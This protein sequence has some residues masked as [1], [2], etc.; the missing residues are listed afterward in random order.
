MAVR[1]QQ[2][3]GQG[4]REYFY[5]IF[6]NKEEAGPEFLRLLNKADEGL[7]SKADDTTGRNGIYCDMIDTYDVLYSKT[8]DPF[9]L[10][11]KGVLAFRLG[12]NVSALAYMRKTVN[13]APADTHYTAAAIKWLHKLE[14]RQ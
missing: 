12:D 6:R 3:D 7:A 8:H 2:G 14:A 9:N 11:Q 13:E 1:V 4:A 5:R 10:Y